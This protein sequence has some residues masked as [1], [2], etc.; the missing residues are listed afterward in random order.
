MLQKKAVR[1]QL[2][3]NVNTISC[4]RQL[5]NRIN[6]KFGLANHALLTAEC[7]KT[8]IIQESEGKTGRIFWL[9][10]NSPNGCTG[11]SHVYNL[12]RT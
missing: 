5:V 7:G 6:E 1:M 3:D 12:K 2:Q 10:D 4:L 9:T 8:K 11:F